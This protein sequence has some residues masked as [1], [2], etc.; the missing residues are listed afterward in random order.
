[1]NR[2]GFLKYLGLGAGAAAVPIAKKLSAEPHFHQERTFDFNKGTL[3]FT[4]EECFEADC[5][6]PLLTVKDQDPDFWK[7]EWAQCY[8][9]LCVHEGKCSCGQDD[10]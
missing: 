9:R 7:T 4:K 3:T 10:V 2:R 6:R 1:M 8:S 5:S